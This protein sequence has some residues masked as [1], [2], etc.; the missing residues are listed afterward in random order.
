MTLSS[1]LLLVTV[2]WLVTFALHS[3]AFLGGAWLLSRSPRLQGDRTQDALWKTA[4]LGGLLTASLHVFG[5]IG[6]GL[7]TWELPTAEV[8]PREAPALVGLPSLPPAPAFELPEPHTTLEPV[9]LPQPVEEPVRARAPL[10]V[11]PTAPSAPWYSGVAHSVAEV[12]QPLAVALWLTIGV[13]LLTLR[14]VQRR[15][16]M[17][18]LE[19][20]QEVTDEQLVAMWQQLVE[21]SGA[22]E[23]LQRRARLTMATGLNSPVAFGEGE[24]C[25]PE[26]TMTDL[27]PAQ[28]RGVLAHEWA[29]HL[30][31]DPHWLLGLRW[32]EALFFFQPLL[33]VARVHQSDAAEGL[34]DAWAARHTGSR[35]AL[36]QSLVTVAAWVHEPMPAWTTSMAAKGSPLTNRV[37]R[38]LADPADAIRD[39]PPPLRTGLVVGLILAIALAVPGIALRQA[40][41]ETQDIPV[42]HTAV[43]DAGITPAHPQDIQLT[44]TNVDAGTW[45]RGEGV[46]LDSEALAVSLRDADS[47]LRVLDEFEGETRYLRVTQD[48]DQKLVYMYQKDG[49]DAPFD[50]AAQRWFAGITDQVVGVTERQSTFGP[51]ALAQ[52][53][54]LAAHDDLYWLGQDDTATFLAMQP[55]GTSIRGARQAA[56]RRVEQA[57][58]ELERIREATLLDYMPTSAKNRGSDPTQRDSTRAWANVGLSEATAQMFLLDRQRKALLAESEAPGSRADRRAASIRAH[59]DELTSLLTAYYTEQTAAARMRGTEV[60]PTDVAARRLEQGL[61]GKPSVRLPRVH[62]FIAMQRAK[63]EALAR[64]GAGAAA[65]N[66]LVQLSL[67]GDA[68]TPYRSFRVRW[69]RD[70]V[71]TTVRAQGVEFAE[72]FERILRVQPDGRF[73]VQETSDAGKRILYISEPGGVRNET[74]LING[75]RQLFGDAAISWLEEIL[76]ELDRNLEAMLPPPPTPPPGWQPPGDTAPPPAPPVQKKSEQLPPPPGQ[77]FTMT[78]AN[79]GA[80]TSVRGEGVVFDSEALRVS[81]RDAGSYLRVLDEFEGETRHLSVTQG[82]NGD[83]AYA[84]QKDWRDAPFGDVEQRWFAGII[85]QVVR[86]TEAQSKSGEL[87][88]AQQASLAAADDLFWLALENEA[89]FASM[90]PSGTMT[91]GA[92]QTA[93]DRVQQA[94]VALQR[95]RESLLPNHLAAFEGGHTAHLTRVDTT[96]AW[97]DVG[98]EQAMAQRRLLR[99]QQLALLAEAD[100]PNSRAARRAALVSAQQ[101]RLSELTVA[102]V[103]AQNRVALADAVSPAMLDSADAAARALGEGLFSIPWAGL[104]RASGVIH[105]QRAQRAALAQAAQGPPDVELTFFTEEARI[106]VKGADVELELRGKGIPSIDLTSPS[107]YLDFTES[108]DLGERYVRIS[109]PDRSVMYDYRIN[110]RARPLDEEAEQWVDTIMWRVV[111]LIVAE[112]DFEKA[113]ARLADQQSARFKSGVYTAYI[114]KDGER[115]VRVQFGSE[116]RFDERDRPVSVGKRGVLRLEERHG[117]QRQWVTY[118]QAPDGSLIQEYGGYGGVTVSNDLAERLLAEAITRVPD[119]AAHRT[120]RICNAG[121]TAAVLAEIERLADDETRAA[122]YTSLMQQPNVRGIDLVVPHMMEQVHSD[123]LT[124]RFLKLLSP[125]QAQAV[126]GAPA[127]MRVVSTVADDNKRADLLLDIATRKG[128]RPDASAVVA[129]ITAMASEYEKGRVLNV[130][131][132]LMATDAIPSSDTHIDQAVATISSDYERASLALKLIETA[133]EMNEGLALTVLD[134]VQTLRSDYE[135]A[136]L[137]RELWEAEPATTASVKAAFSK[138]IGTLDLPTELNIPIND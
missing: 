86:A 20:R 51:L 102:Y 103:M 36:A 124:V 50:E 6:P 60:D 24:V 16:F 98:M 134:I 31:R 77:A 81:L 78:F 117:E 63:R 83:L 38:L 90:Q 88:L 94:D 85:D 67:D 114:W 121:G 32:L 138:I 118:S 53:A 68:T 112:A 45:V 37:K 127:Y 58:R 95:V 61:F 105:M 1:D 80:R 79:I 40:A 47:Y 27:T 39:L 56:V 43:G 125:E 104:P 73:E 93:A 49:R 100:G 74:Y 91:S 65:Q 119:F 72:G 3:T 35:K 135:K 75:N 92:K 48:D 136:V 33:R 137:L 57:S 11:A 54:V 71:T 18:A 76:A 2:A 28:Q 99:A 30:R 123:F 52:Q 109:R 66:S 101:E 21:N 9:P 115:M 129:A 111:S 10:V 59:S 84:Y 122:Y 64:S 108:N 26:R 12:W 46:M 133:P 126:G 7:V 29:H 14:A 42:Q 5:G 41:P 15:R 44:F 4:V 96:L 113:Q 82:D 132:P 128:F 87:A 69:E 23:R 120:E 116:V 130:Y 19:P 62:E 107:G 97:T 34:C 13:L 8:P 70:G 25:I 22:S 131:L 55:A 89:A 110:G 17:Q 106:A